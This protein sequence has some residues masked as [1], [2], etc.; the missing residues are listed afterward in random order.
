MAAS[1]VRGFSSRADSCCHKLPRQTQNRSNMFNPLK[2]LTTPEYLF[3]PRQI[4]IRIKRQFVKP[5]QT[6]E[7]VRLPWGTS[8]RI[9]PAEVIGSN[10]WYYGVFEL[11]VAE[12]IARLMDHGETAIDIG[13]N[14]GQMTTL[15]R[16][17]A[18]SEGRVIAFEAHP[19]IFAELHAN[20]ELASQQPDASQIDLHN[21]GLS[22]RQGAGSLD[23]GP[24]WQNNRGMARV[25]GLAA[26]GGARIKIQLQM[27]DDLL[28]PDAKCGVCKIDVEGHE[29]QVLRG[30]TKALA[31]GAIRDVVFEDLAG[32]GTPVQ[33]FLLGH[34]FTLFAL[35]Q[36]LFGPVLRHLDNERPAKPG[37]TYNFL[38]TKNPERA[39]VR[40]RRRGWQCLGL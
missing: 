23:P 27:L 24:E 6:I 17:L 40:F 35:H 25:T 18:G 26:N 2:P 11:L 20:M 38:A 31:R 3:R 16:R 32:S 37:D 19:E 4:A 14:V 13:A 1:L 28:L 9:R 5:T 39:L 34:G 8:F 33:Q 10:I 29:L 15:M 30:A 36:R 21:V 22:D 7:T 12:T